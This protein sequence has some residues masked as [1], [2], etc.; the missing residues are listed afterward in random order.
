MILCNDFTIILTSALR[1]HSMVHLSTEKHKE[2]AAIVTD[3][4]EDS[5]GQATFWLLCSKACPLLLVR[6]VCRSLWK[7]AISSSLLHSPTIE[8]FP[9]PIISCHFSRLVLREHKITYWRCGSVYHSALSMRSAP[10]LHQNRLSSI[11]VP[12]TISSRAK[13]F[14][15]LSIGRLCANFAPN[16]AVAML[17]AA[18]PISAG[19]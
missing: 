8:D 6:R 13:I 5:S 17:A 16:G 15:N 19:R 12:I 10:S 9:N 3:V 14:F 2:T 18:I 4:G 7:A 11:L 1:R